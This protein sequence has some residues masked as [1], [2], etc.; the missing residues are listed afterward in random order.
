[1]I[2]KENCASVDI[3]LKTMNFNLPR[4]YFSIMMYFFHPQN[5]GLLGG[6]LKKKSARNPSFHNK[7]V[8][9]IETNEIFD[10]FP[11]YV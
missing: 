1:M 6:K 9:I 10:F 11:N 3:F 7:T 5:M 4:R 8:T 2:A